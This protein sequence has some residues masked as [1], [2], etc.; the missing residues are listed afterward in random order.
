[1]FFLTH[2]RNS[3]NC[4]L[5]IHK[6]NSWVHVIACCLLPVATKQLIHVGAHG[7]TAGTQKKIRIHIFFWDTN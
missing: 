1:M 5:G 2:D 4:V 7:Y 3:T 6:E